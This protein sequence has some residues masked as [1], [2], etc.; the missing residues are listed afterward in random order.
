MLFLQPK[1]IVITTVFTI[2]TSSSIF[3]EIGYKNEKKKLFYLLYC[4][5]KNSIHE[6]LQLFV[7]T[8]ILFLIT[9]LCT[10]MFSKYYCNQLPRISNKRNKKVSLEIEVTD[11]LR[12]KSFFIEYIIIYINS[13]LFSP[14]S[15][16][17]L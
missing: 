11:R 12:I 13:L 14:N 4:N 15:T 6:D 3:Y 9:I 7:V 1:K 2:D 5:S 17:P 16:H 8:S 10:M